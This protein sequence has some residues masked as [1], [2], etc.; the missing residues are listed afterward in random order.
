MSLKSRSPNFTRFFTG[1]I[2]VLAVAILFFLSNRYSP[3]DSPTSA[4]ESRFVARTA[5]D[6]EE[7]EDLDLLGA[8]PLAPGELPYVPN[9]E[10][11]AASGDLSGRANVVSRA[12]RDPFSVDAPILIVNGREEPSGEPLGRV[13]FGGVT[14]PVHYSQLRFFRR[15]TGAA[16]N[17]GATGAVG[18]AGASGARDTIGS[19]Q[20]RGG[21]QILELPAAATAAAMREE[22]SAQVARLREEGYVPALVLPSGERVIPTGELNVLPQPSVTAN[23]VKAAMY[24]FGFK[25]VRAATEADPWWVIA[26]TSALP[27]E[28]LE[29]ASAVAAQIPCRFSEPN[30]IR[31]V[32]KRYIPSDP[33][34]KDQWH[35]RNR[36][37][38]SGTTGADIAA[39]SAWNVTAGSAEVVIAVFDDGFDLA[40]A[41][42]PRSASLV[43]CRDFVRGTD[44]P[45]PADADPKDPDN[46]GTPVWGLIAGVHGNGRGVAGVAP[47]V[48]FMLLRNPIE[49]DERA[50]AD[51]IRWAADKGAH[52]MSNSWGYTDPGSVVTSA[53]AYA[54]TKGRGGKGTLVLFASGNENADIGRTNDLSNNVNVFAIGATDHRDKRT[55][56]SNY[57]DRLFAVTPAGYGEG[58]G[59]VATDRSGSKGYTSTSYTNVTG[60]QF[61][62]TSG[63]CPIAAGIAGLVFSVNPDFTA[64]EVAR[65][66][67]ESADK[68]NRTAANYD[69]AGH[70][71]TYGYGRLNAAAAVA[72]ARVVASGGGPTAGGSVLFREDFEAVADG[73]RSVAGKWSATSTGATGAVLQ[74][75]LVSGNRMLRASNLQG[76]ATWKT[77]AIDIGGRSGVSIRLKFAEVGTLEAADIIEGYYQV[78]GKT[79]VRWF[80]HADDAGSAFLEKSVTGLNGSR[81]V[82]WVSFSNGASEEWRLDEIEVSGS[83]AA[84][85]PPPATSNLVFR[86][87]FEASA[88]GA[89][90]AKDRWTLETT[91]SGAA[92]FAVGS[93]SGNKM[94]RASNLQG[95][96]GAVG[97][98]G[99]VS[100]ATWRTGSIDLAGRR[101]VTVRLKFAEVGTLEASDTIEAWY[102][103]D[104]GTPIRWLS[105]ADDAGSAFIEKSVTG[106]NGSR[107]VIWVSFSN[108]ASE[109]WRLDDIEVE[110]AGGTATTRSA[111]VVFRENFQEAGAG[112]APSGAQ[113]STQIEHST[114]GSLEVARV[115]RR[116]FLAGRELSGGGTWRTDPLDIS[117]LG[118]VALRLRLS[119]IGVMESSDFV[120][121]RFSIDG[122]PSTLWFHH[123]GQVPLGARGAEKTLSGLSGK[124]L[125]VTLEFRCSGKSEA[126][127]IDDFSITGER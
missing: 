117:R 120:T 39:D 95:A 115:G 67:R 12:A 30:W 34:F 108:G 124:S 27:E 63:A 76:T 66:L 2:V 118:N 23:D 25:I 13:R 92:I 3:P 33:Y 60:N 75:G 38:T 93:V 24:G 54:R 74:T 73:A 107:L 52:V 82:I 61:D 49:M 79:P 53:L 40:H 86:E 47:S 42:L 31:E 125:V 22:R 43:N 57:G 62:G 51:A 10:A 119:E 64:E 69:G 121:A 98:A 8:P 32:E 101:N 55:T 59:L 56:Y 99:A 6:A 84:A 96:V 9:S 29:A 20:A 123:Q 116:R 68:V 106:L 71:R 72:H 26:T 88:D 37:Q 100:A 89:T 18:S 97:A 102:Q 109:E 46:H 70:S 78:D 122:G 45:T 112:S 104:G 103:L 48:K 17:V 15:A 110:G 5:H 113:W 50:T 11:P 28:V 16:G 1:F 90:S 21:M 94:L 35:L 44:V 19:T 91:S 111:P 105:H 58:V 80:S 114:G 4:V 14:L 83:G 126:W 65:V 85:A 41:D 127:R 36:G 7:A 87:D 77:A 81:L